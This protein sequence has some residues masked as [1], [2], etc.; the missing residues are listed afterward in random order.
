MLP[1]EVPTR[2]G[3][4]DY[5]PFLDDEKICYLWM[6][7]KNFGEQPITAQLK[8]SVQDSPNSAGVMIDVVRSLKIAKDRNIGGPLI[9]VSSYFFKHPPKQIIDSEA[10]ELV[11]KFIRG[12]ISN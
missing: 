3:P 5:V 10:K 11:E 8:L 6:K 1:Y 4:S 7:G 2:I 9:G 12:E